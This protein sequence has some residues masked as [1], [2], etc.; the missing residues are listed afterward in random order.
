MFLKM[1]RKHVET[2][3]KNGWAGLDGQ[4]Q[5]VLRGLFLGNKK[6]IKCGK[7]R[8][9]SNAKMGSEKKDSDDDDDGEQHASS[10]TTAMDPARRNPSATST[11]DPFNIRGRYPNNHI[12][13]G[14]LEPM[15]GVVIGNY[16][17]IDDDSVFDGARMAEALDSLFGGK[18]D[19]DPDVGEVE[20]EREMQGVVNAV[21]DPNFVFIGF[22]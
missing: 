21:D 4:T 3:D 8:G 15:P 6:K 12:L 1:A 19:E 20:L 9:R 13:H 5:N 17:T 14:L 10:S 16:F 22:F 7:N 2:L 18:D 11:W